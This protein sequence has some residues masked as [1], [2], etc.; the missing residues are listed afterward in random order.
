MFNFY[1]M[2]YY[3]KVSYTLLIIVFLVFFGSLVPNFIRD[4]FNSNTILA[5]TAMVVLFGFILHMFF[6]T[7][8][9]I[10]KEKLY[11]KCGFFSYKPI[12]IR[13]MKKISKS[14]NIISSPAASFDRIEITYGKFEELIISPRHKIKFIEDLQKINPKLKNNLKILAS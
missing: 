2:I 6:N 4:G 5:F 11:I 9:R 3:S 14:S 7:T 13:E 12:N 1:L 8:Y 10:D